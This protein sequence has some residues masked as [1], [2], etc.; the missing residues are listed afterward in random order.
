MAVGKGKNVGGCITPDVQFFAPSS[1]THLARGRGGTSSVG[2][3]TPVIEPGY[4]LDQHAQMLLGMKLFDIEQEQAGE[5][6]DLLLPP[7][8][9]P[10]TVPRPETANQQLQSAAPCTRAQTRV[11]SR[12]T[13][14]HPESCGPPCRYVKRKGG[15]RDG[16]SCTNCHQCFWVGK[17]VQPAPASDKGRQEADMKPKTRRPDRQVPTSSVGTVGHP[18]TCAEPCVEAWQPGGCS[19]G[20]AC[21]LLGGT[22][23]ET[24]LSEAFET[25]ASC[26][27]QCH[28]CRPMQQLRTVAADDSASS[29]AAASTLRVPEAAPSSASQA[30]AEEMPD[31][32]GFSIGSL[33]HPFSCADPCKYAHK[34]RGCKDGRWC[35]RCHFCVWYRYPSG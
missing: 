17:Q 14:G 29:S 28:R 25:P 11:I 3:A 16:Q 23:L 20:S 30:P 35:D 6:S 18:L 7:P 31:L 32:P 15:C 4:W 2:T 33:G 9:P 19:R 1:A 10:H 27:L 12:G 24:W 13:I 26:F 8:P 34:K 5:E 21:Q 22:E